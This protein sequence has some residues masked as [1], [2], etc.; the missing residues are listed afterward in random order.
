VATSAAAKETS[1]IVHTVIPPHHPSSVGSVTRQV[2]DRPLVFVQAGD[3]GF[4]LGVSFAS[5][6]RASSKTSVRSLIS[7]GAP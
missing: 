7:A 3:L 4:L 6:R 1:R 2:G 5:R